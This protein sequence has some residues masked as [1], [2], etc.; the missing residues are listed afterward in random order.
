MLINYI[1]YVFSCELNKI[2]LMRKIV[3]Y[4][5][6][7]ATFVYAPLFIKVFWNQQSINYLCSV[8]CCPEDS[9]WT[10]SLSSE[11]GRQVIGFFSIPDR[12][13]L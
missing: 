13:V 12:T 6:Q 5:K 7:S 1:C 8:W 11:D 3:L 10:T 9:N 2:F 4:F